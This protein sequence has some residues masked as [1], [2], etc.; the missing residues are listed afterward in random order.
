MRDLE[1]DILTTIQCF[2]QRGR[3]GITPPGQALREFLTA[4]FTPADYDYLDIEDLRP[5]W[6][7]MLGM[8][9]RSAQKFPPE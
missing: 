6:V 5:V 8:M 7:A 2:A 4:F 1:G 3:P 9:R